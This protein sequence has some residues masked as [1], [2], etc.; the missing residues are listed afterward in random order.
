LQSWKYCKQCK[1]T[2]FEK[3]ES[4]KWRHDVQKLMKISW[5]LVAVELAS[6]YGSIS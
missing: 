3:P 6:W 4:Q 5:S 1:L 2:R